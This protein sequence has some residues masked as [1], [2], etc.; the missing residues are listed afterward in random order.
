[1]ASP[2]ATSLNHNHAPGIL[3]GALIACEYGDMAI[4]TVKIGD[5]VNTLSDGPQVVRWVG[6]AMLSTQAVQFQAGALGENRPAHTLLVSPTQRMVV[7]GWQAEVLF[8]EARVLV[9]AEAL[10]NGGSISLT[11]APSETEFF[12][13]LFDKHEAIAA[14]GT[15]SESFYPSKIALGSLPAKTRAALHKQVPELDALDPTHPFAPVHPTIS[16]VEAALLR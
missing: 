9:A 11:E 5:I 15:P 7:S 6:G 13:I 16:A 10:L 12:H 3:R 1:M 8:G 2:E 14:N 4:E